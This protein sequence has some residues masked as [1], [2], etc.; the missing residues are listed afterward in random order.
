MEQ[1]HFMREQILAN[2]EQ[3]G[4]KTMVTFI[5]VETLF[6][7][8]LEIPIHVYGPETHMTAIVGMALGKTPILD[9]EEMKETQNKSKQT[10]NRRIRT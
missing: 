6:A 5:S 10:K 1:N 9:P 4:I 8:A 2:L 3:T 7:P